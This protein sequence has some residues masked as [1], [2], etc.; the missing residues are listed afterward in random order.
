MHLNP[1]RAE[2]MVVLKPKLQPKDTCRV[3]AK[4]AHAALRL[5]KTERSMTD[6]EALTLDAITDAVYPD[7]SSGVVFRYS[8]NGVVSHC[9][10]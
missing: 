4:D 1:M 8:F 9:E 10:P 6:S 5:F 7:C 3:S 2:D